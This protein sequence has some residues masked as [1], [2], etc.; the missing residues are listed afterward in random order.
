MAKALPSAGKWAIQK[1]PGSV[2]GSEALKV[3]PLEW[4]WAREWATEMVLAW[5]VESKSFF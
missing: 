1:G 4:D 3:S 5:A 2:A